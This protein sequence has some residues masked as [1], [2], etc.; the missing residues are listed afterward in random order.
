MAGFVP[1]EGE[2]QHLAE[3]LAAGEDWLLCLIT[4]PLTPAET[5]AAA[6][7]TAAEATFSGYARKTLT[8]SVSGTTWGTPASGAPDGSWSSETSVATS[9]YNAS[10][11][12]QWTAG[13]G[14]SA[15][16]YGYFYLGATSGKLVFAEYFAT[17]RTINDGAVI[18][19]V[20][21]FSFA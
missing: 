8:R 4:S 17:P 3:H 9:R 11:P 12:Q 10:S 20:P 5:D 14:V 18:N 21:S 2:L 16:L 1:D 6:T 7:W 13:S 19:L 15:T